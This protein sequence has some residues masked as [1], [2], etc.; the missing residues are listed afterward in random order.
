MVVTVIQLNIFNLFALLSPSIY[1]Q[2]SLIFILFFSLVECL[3]LIK[4]TLE[5]L[6]MQK[7]KHRN[8]KPDNYSIFSES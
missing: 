6:N 3:V 8:S 7:D 4:I 2:S 1:R 5:V